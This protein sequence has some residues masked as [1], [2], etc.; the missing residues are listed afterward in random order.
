MTFTASG[1]KSSVLSSVSC[2]ASSV[3]PAR[4]EVVSF[5][6]DRDV[7]LQAGGAGQ[8]G[9]GAGGGAAGRGGERTRR[10]G[11]D[12]HRT[13][14]SRRDC[15]CGEGRGGT[16][17]PPAA[18]VRPSQ[19]AVCEHNTPAPP[20]HTHTLST[21]IHWWRGAGRDGP[22]IAVRACPSRWR[23]RRLVTGARV[24]SVLFQ[25]EGCVCR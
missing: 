20:T 24:T 8:G 6:P 14:G 12:L 13:R 17:G 1:E 19:E 25:K 2:S 22:R 7:S 21:N 23:R 5:E 18:N 4:T 9:G 11:H 10:A 16:S 3:L 15:E